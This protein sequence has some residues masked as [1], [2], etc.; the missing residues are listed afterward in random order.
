MSWIAKLIKNEKDRS[1]K[2]SMTMSWLITLNRKIRPTRVAM[3]E[4]KKKSYFA[5]NSKSPIS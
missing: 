5:S 2:L 1:L 3:T 4:L